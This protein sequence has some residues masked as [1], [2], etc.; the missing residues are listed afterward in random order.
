MGPLVSL[1]PK[2]EFYMWDG[3]GM[4]TPVRMI[5]YNMQVLTSIDTNLFL[6]PC[7]GTRI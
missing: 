4:R 7:L 5:S 3:L 2:S 6:K 1:I